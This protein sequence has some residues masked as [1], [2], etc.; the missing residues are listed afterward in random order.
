LRRS[1]YNFS[2]IPETAVI[3]IDPD[4]AGIINLWQEHILTDLEDTR[5]A[6]EAELIGILTNRRLRKERVR[7]VAALALGHIGVDDSRLQIRQTLLAQLRQPRLKPFLAICITATGAP[8]VQ[9]VNSIASM[10]FTYWAKWGAGFKIRPRFY[11]RPCNT[12]TQK[13]EGT[14][15]SPLA[16]WGCLPPANGWRSGWIAMI[17]NTVSKK[18]GRC[19]ALSR[20][21]AK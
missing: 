17:P 5:A 19:A 9:A 21:W 13:C 10:R 12:P 20:P 4:L 8:A 2:P 3:A 1:R 7:G 16:S 11:L 15:L 18:A 14:Q 6:I